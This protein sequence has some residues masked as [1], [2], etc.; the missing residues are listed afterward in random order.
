M[1]IFHTLLG[2][3]LELDCKAASIVQVKFWYGNEVI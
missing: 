3:N 2:I 1:N